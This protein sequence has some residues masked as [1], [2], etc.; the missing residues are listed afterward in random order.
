[1]SNWSAIQ[2]SGKMT[3]SARAA[4]QLHTHTHTHT[5]TVLKKNV[6]EIIKYPHKSGPHVCG[7][8]SQSQGPYTH[9]HIH[10]HTQKAQIYKCL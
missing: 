2:W 8:Q 3:V 1:M 9:T 6:S 7:P 4:G 5:H 10:T